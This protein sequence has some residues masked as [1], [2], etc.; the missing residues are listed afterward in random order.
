[1]GRKVFKEYLTQMRLPDPRRRVGSDSS[2]ASSS[3]A[4][5][6]LDDD[7]LART[8]AEGAA[9]VEK[10]GGSFNELVRDTFPPA[11]DGSAPTG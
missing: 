9:E 4:Q 8:K 3:G 5:H 10:F 7:D 2:G 11:R 1:M 6:H